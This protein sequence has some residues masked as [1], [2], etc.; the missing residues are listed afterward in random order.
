LAEAAPLAA[1]LEPST[2]ARSPAIGWALIAVSVMISATLILFGPQI[3]GLMPMTSELGGMALV[4][5]IIFAPMIA[6][7]LVFARLDGF[8]ALRRG[9][10]AGAW[11]GIGIASGML[12][13]GMAALLSRLAGTLVAGQGAPLGGLIVAGVAMVL[14]QT[15]SEEIFFRGWVMKALESR[16]G[17]AAAIGLSSLFFMAFHV[18]TGPRAP[19]T[20]VNL[21]LGGVWFGLLAWRS[22]GLIA[23]VLAH[24]GWN[25]SEDLIAGL[26]PNPGS[27]PFGALSDWDLVGSPLWGGS[28]EGLNT[29][30][31]MAVVLIALI[32]PLVWR[33]AAPAPAI[34]PA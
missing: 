34:Q 22:G 1:P 9:D 15:A 3:A 8:S 23:P 6:L 17:V 12:G 20:L 30:I 32:V 2:G 26:T 25:A 11:A 31:G 18:L 7:G 19:M 29:S 21:L 5:A 28:E 27:G 13:L 24:F 10:A 16:V 14:F 4:Y 33:P